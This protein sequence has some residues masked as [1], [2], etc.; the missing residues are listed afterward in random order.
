[1]EEDT[2]RPK[3][4]YRPGDLEIFIRPLIGIYIALAF[5]FIFNSVF[6]GLL[7]GA[8]LFYIPFPSRREDAGPMLMVNRIIFL[9]LMIAIII[10]AFNAPGTL[11]LGLDMGGAWFMPWEWN[12]SAIIFG[13]VWLIS[14]VTGLLS[15]ME[16]RQIIGSIMI[17][18]SF[19]L[20]ATG[21]GSQE[22]GAAFFGQWWPVV[23]NTLGGITE[24]ISEIFSSIQSTFGD[25]FTMLTCPTCYATQLL[26]STVTENPT[27]KTGTYGIEF[28]SFDIDQIYAE[29]PFA[30]TTI[31]K[32]EGA[33]EA[34]NVELYLNTTLRQSSLNKEWIPLDK[35]GLKGDS[36]IPIG[37]RF[38]QQDSRQTMFFFDGIDCSVI[39]KYDLRYRYLPFR[40]TVSYEYDVDA[41]LEVQFMSIE[42]WDRKVRENTLYTSK[43]V[44]K[45]SSS[46]ARLSLGTLDQPI[47]ESDTPFNIQLKLEA[48]DQHSSIEWANITIKI[49]K[50]FG[51]PKGCYPHAPR[52]ITDTGDKYELY[53]PLF[54]HGGTCGRTNIVYCEFDPINIEKATETFLVYG[55]ATYRISEYEEGESSLEFGST[56]CP[57]TTGDSTPQETEDNR[58]N[59]GYCDARVSTHNGKCILGMGGCGEDSDCCTYSANCNWAI[60]SGFS[61]T[62]DSDGDEARESLECR[63]ELNEGNGICCYKDAEDNQCVAAF[64]EWKSLVNSKEVELYGILDSSDIDKI[65]QAF[66]S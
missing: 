41:S 11:G 7:A 8:F 62:Y 5:G 63:T 45:M 40:A 15:D 64:N 54:C 20:F 36:V 50:A 56:T 47:R 33:F 9:V 60:T 27:G 26:N 2:D 32:N 48:A 4:R 66:T 49:P 24:P 34:R 18:I 31:I 51:E 28:T 14:F 19:V 13:G 25:A 30:I 10:L 16:S 22:V 38:V 12:T 37:E 3:L 1:M 23:H 65:N 52:D 43:V 61:L 29:T 44:S 58:F 53:W 57:T 46:P 6:L 39:N 21:V 55:G 42:E 59:S 17:L 35:F